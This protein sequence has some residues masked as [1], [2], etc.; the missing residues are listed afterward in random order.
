MITLM[1]SSLYMDLLKGIGRDRKS[2]VFFFF[3]RRKQQIK[4]NNL[5]VLY[6]KSVRSVSCLGMTGR[7]LK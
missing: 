1:A 5:A 4:K 3:S 6:E 7:R 2:E